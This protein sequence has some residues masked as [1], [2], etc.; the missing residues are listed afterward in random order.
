MGC[1]HRGR[2]RPGL[3]GETGGDQKPTLE[4]SWHELLMGA[5][6]RRQEQAAQHGK[7]DDEWDGTQQISYGSLNSILPY[8]RISAHDKENRWCQKGKCQA[9]P[10]LYEQ[11]PPEVGTRATLQHPD[12]IFPSHHEREAH[13]ESDSPEKRQR[14]FSKA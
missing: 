7:H 11:V 2:V 3:V 14:D 6:P 9:H 13:P 1:D 5:A 8:D 12:P 10:A 4:G